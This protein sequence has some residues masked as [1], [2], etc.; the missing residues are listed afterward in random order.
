MEFVIVVFVI[1]IASV[2]VVNQRSKKSFEAQRNEFRAFADEHGLELELSRPAEQG[3]RQIAPPPRTTLWVLQRGGSERTASYYLRRAGSEAAVFE[4]RAS[5]PSSA[6]NSSNY[7][8]QRNVIALVPLLT[9]SPSFLISSKKPMH[10]YRHSKPEKLGTGDASF[11]DAYWLTSENSNATLAIVDATVASALH[12]H[13]RRWPEIEVE[14]G[15]RH[16]ACAGPHEMG[17]AERMEL[18]DTA[19]VIADILFG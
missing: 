16:L 18:L 4:Y 19:E 12:H 13:F 10:R 8:M 14:A 11:D 5:S 6:G 1:V 3:E 17:P 9:S 7:R 2:V 15:D